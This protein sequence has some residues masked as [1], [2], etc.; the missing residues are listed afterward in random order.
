MIAC[1][2]C[3][4][5]K[6]LSFVFRHT[7][8]RYQSGC[9]VCFGTG[10]EYMFD[11]MYMSCGCS[12]GVGIAKQYVECGVCF[13]MTPTKKISPSKNIR[14]HLSSLIK[15]RNQP[16]V[17]HIEQMFAEGMT[18]ENKGNWHVDHIKPIKSFLDEGVTN[19]AIINHHI[20]LQPLWA[21]DNISKTDAYSNPEH[22]KLLS[23]HTG[24]RKN[25]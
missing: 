16:V 3:N 23:M 22:D 4:E 9:G 14:S 18:W 15:S 17:S 2:F 13:G 6:D 12:Y 24:Y 7:E 11:D 25:R 19:P 8:V 21:C 1:E 10:K 20:N 5:N